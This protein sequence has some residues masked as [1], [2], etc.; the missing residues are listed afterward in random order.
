MTLEGMDEELAKTLAARGIRTREDL[1][2]QSVEDLEGIEALDDARAGA[3]D[4]GRPRP[5]VR[6]RRG[7]NLRSF[8]HV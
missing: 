8:L 5:L 4:H 2:D 7:V 3:A 1:A 6:R